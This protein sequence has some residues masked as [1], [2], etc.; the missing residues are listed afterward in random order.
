MFLDIEHR[1]SDSPYIERVWRCRSTGDGQLTSIASASWNLC[2][3]EHAGQF[4]AAVHG[5]ET[6]TTRTPVPADVVLLGIS[7]ATGSAVPHLAPSHIVG[8]AIG[9]PDATDRRFYLAG[10]TWHRPDYESAEGFVARLARADVLVRDPL[11]ANELRGASTDVTRRTVQRRFRAATGLTPGSVRQ[12]ERA[13]RAAVLL[14][15][16][17]NLDDVIHRLGYYDGPHLRRSLKRF[18]GWT[19]AQLKS[20]RPTDQMSL[21]YTTSHPHSS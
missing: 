9:L 2:F 14:R 4:H 8:R 6:R 3:W 15:D 17:L 19:P 7:F 16:G 5:P 21:L 11:V 18:I 10:S 13:R 20:P 12:I 1:P